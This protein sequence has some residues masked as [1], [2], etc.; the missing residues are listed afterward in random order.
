L[1]LVYGSE[2]VQE[3]GRCI[4]FIGKLCNNFSMRREAHSLAIYF[5]DRYMLILG[6][7][8]TGKQ[9]KLIAMTALLLGLKIDDGIMSRKLCHEYI[10]HME[11]V[12]QLASRTDHRDKSTQKGK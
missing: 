5:M 12:L 10:N 3:R 1:K 9:L 6:K 11:C 7:E 4:E 2:L 8:V